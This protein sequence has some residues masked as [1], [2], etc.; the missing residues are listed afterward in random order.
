MMMYMASKY[1]REVGGL[2]YEQVMNE[3]AG[4]VNTTMKILNLEE[5]QKQKNNE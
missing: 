5:E 4:W 1:Q 3:D 2:T